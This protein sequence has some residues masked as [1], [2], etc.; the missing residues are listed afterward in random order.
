M[1]LEEE[2]ERKGEILFINL[3]KGEFHHHPKK[4]ENYAKYISKPFFLS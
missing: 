2:A 1:Q 3:F 4:K